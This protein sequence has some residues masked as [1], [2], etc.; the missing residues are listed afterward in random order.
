MLEMGK[1][2]LFINELKHQKLDITGLCE[3]RWRGGGHFSFEDNLII[4]SRGDKGE[5]GVA[6]ILDQT[7]KSSCLG[8]DTVS[9]RILVVHLDTKPVKTTIIKVYARTSTSR[10]EDKEDF[11]NQL[12]ATKDAIKDRNALIIM[13]DFNA[14]VGDEASKHQ[15]LSPRG[16]GKR[17]DSGEN[18]LSF[19]QANDLMILNTWF[20]HHPRR[21]F[22]W[23][24]PDKKTKNQIDYIFVSKNLFSSFT[25][26]RTRPGDDC[27]TD[28]ILVTAKVKLKVFRK[29]QENNPMIRYDLDKL[30]EQENYIKYS[31]DTEN[32]F[33]TLLTTQEELSPEQ[34]WQEMKEIVHTAANNSLGKKKTK[35]TKSWISARTRE[36]AE[37]KREARK[38]RTNGTI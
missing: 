5:A 35:K 14:K 27:D 29:K 8:Y 11:Y 30:T 21:K 38:K 2:H 15:G 23:V 22:T 37:K 13:D 19:S 25:D 16:L 24:S 32:K 20:E 36:M 7:T 28:H 9:D 6:I 33:E 34:M 31:I 3:C 4:Y 12:Q 17:N 26:F 10:D 18:L 1:L